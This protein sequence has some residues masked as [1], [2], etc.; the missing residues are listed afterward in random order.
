MLAEVV[1]RLALI[2]RQYRAHFIKLKGHDEIN[3]C[4]CKE[5]RRG[6]LILDSLSFHNNKHSEMVGVWIIVY[7]DP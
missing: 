5:V 3:P 2:G 4:G 1:T 7:A 6:Q